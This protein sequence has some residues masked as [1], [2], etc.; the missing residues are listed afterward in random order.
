MLVTVGE[1][2]RKPLRP[3][4]LVARF[5]G[6][7]FSV[8][9]PETKLEHAQIIAE[10]LRENVSNAIPGMLDG[11]KIPNVTISLGVTEY[12]P[13]YTLEAMIASADV[14]MYQA[15]KNGRNRVQLAHD[16]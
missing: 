5:G 1:N 6:E 12:K 16:A 13:N 8:L 11:K 2:I 9:L 14:A 7:E 3:N 10:R 4:D 15:K